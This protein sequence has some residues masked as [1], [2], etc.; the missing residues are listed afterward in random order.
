MTELMDNQI[1]D[2]RPEILWTAGLARAAGERLCGWS[3]KSGTK[4]RSTLPSA[5]RDA[6]MVCQANVTMNA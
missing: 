5:I 1:N 2:L 3:R 6:V 4:L